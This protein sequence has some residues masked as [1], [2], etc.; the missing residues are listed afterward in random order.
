MKLT[1]TIR[2]IL[3]GEKPDPGKMYPVI[4]LMSSSKIE[5]I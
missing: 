5:Q 2:T 3:L 4:P 1:L